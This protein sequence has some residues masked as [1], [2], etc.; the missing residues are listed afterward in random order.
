MA[1]AL[2]SARVRSNDSASIR[3]GYTIPEAR[4]IVDNVP[5]ARKQVVNAFPYRYG[6]L[7]W[8]R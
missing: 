1:T 8:K 3:R 7:L 5:A 6:I 4:S 2:A